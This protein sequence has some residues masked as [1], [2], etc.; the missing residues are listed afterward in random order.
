MDNAEINNFESLDREYIGVESMSQ[1]KVALVT[2]GSRGIGRGICV[3][4]AKVGYAV[5]VNYATRADAAEEVVASSARGLA[6]I[7]RAQMHLNGA[8]G[9]TTELADNLG[10]AAT[11]EGCHRGR[12]GR[13]VDHQC[14]RSLVHAEETG[15]VLSAID[16]DYVGA[17]SLMLIPGTPLYRDYEVGDFEIP[18][19]DDMLRELRAMMA[20]THLSRGLFH[21]NHASNYLPIRAR[22]PKD[23]AATLELIDNALT[24]GVALRPTT[25]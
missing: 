2:G 23:K 25:S 24:G 17:L 6:G 10:N 5:V 7:L 19:P 22:F 12:A 4:M 15:R 14:P 11:D 8:V 13:T 1:Q 20:S 16:P 21:A 3:E 9:D 18:K